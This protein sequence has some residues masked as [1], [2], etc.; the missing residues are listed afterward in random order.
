MSLTES[1]GGCMFIV[2]ITGEVATEFH[3][4]IGQVCVEGILIPNCI[5]IPTMPHL[6]MY[7][8]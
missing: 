5:M 7:L 6:P 1:L 3:L 8:T 2:I 4:S